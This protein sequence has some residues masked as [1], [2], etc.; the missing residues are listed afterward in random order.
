[1]PARSKLRAVPLTAT[2]NRSRWFFAAHLQGALGTGAGYVALLL[3]A[4]E[5]IGNAWGATAVL[6]ADLAPAMLL[7]PLLGGLIDRRGRLR[8]AIAADVIGALAFLGLSFAH[9]A[10]QLIVL[11]LL[12][13]LGSAL[14]RP[15]TC[16]LLPAI[17]EP[18]RLSQANGTFGAVR[19]IGQLIGPALAAGVLV[20]ASPELVLGLN[21]LTFAISALLLTR[22]RGRL[23]A[24][25]ATAPEATEAN[26]ASVLKDRLTRSLVL[27][28]GAVM[29]VAGATNV[30][31]LVLA[32]TELHGGGSGF[33]LLVAAF[34]CGMLAGSLL[35]P[36]RD[37][38]LRTRYLQAIAA[39]GTGLI[40]TA[41]SPTLPIA[42]IAFSLAGLGN[43]LFCVTVR[44]LMQKL[45]PEHAHGRA[46][47]LL[48]AIDSWGFGAAIVAGGALAASLGGRVTFA[49][50][51]TLALL[52]L[53]QAQR[54]LRQTH[55]RTPN[56]V[57]A[58]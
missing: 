15:A 1:L 3:L 6:I 8:C 35:A 20:I 55:L 19:E 43:G 10:A 45:I 21:A 17:V 14:L 26:V 27:T 52:V 42:M 50:A 11:A 30:A 53:I 31:E 25:E 39:L 36:K 22:L 34:G 41:A 54:T 48:D 7:G 47:G 37:A 16:A 58:T 56:F 24:A 46:F 18:S 33:A 23:N 57:P 49:L 32:K 29:L 5:Q 28:S 40:A 38:A 13:G 44:V 4:Y 9:G 2:D 12:A 51:G